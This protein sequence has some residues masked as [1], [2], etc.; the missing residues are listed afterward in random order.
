MSDGQLVGLVGC[1]RDRSM[2]AL[3]AENL[4]HLSAICL[5]LSVYT[6]TVRH[7]NKVN[8]ELRLESNLLTPRQLEIA[9]LVALGRKNAGIG[10][11]IWI[12]EH[13]VKQALK[14]MFCK[15]GVL[16]RTEMLARLQTR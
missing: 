16:S 7:R 13:T 8:S 12:T 5:H 14:R 11:E 9:R 1:R 4:A 2:P 3:D 10:R 6:A 15:L